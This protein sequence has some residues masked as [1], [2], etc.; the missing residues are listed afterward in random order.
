MDRE[1][2]RLRWLNTIVEW[3]KSGLTQKDWCLAFDLNLNTFNWWKKKL[4]PRKSIKQHVLL[5]FPQATQMYLY[6]HLI[7]IHCSFEKLFR[8]IGE[9]FS[10]E[11]IESSYFI[12]LGKHRT[13]LKIFYLDEDG[14]NILFKRLERGAFV[15]DNHPKTGKFL[16]L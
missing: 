10:D 2:I 3:K 8:M 4:F 12:F 14:P 1:L 6:N 5:A 13:Y 7:D 11:T 16:T 15:L 9:S